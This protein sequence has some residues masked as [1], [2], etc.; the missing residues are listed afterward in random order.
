MTQDISF[1]KMH[2]IGNDFVIIDLRHTS[3]LLSPTLIRAIC[4]RQ[5]GIGCDQLVTLEPATMQDA[6]AWVKFYN[7]DGSESGACG[8]ASRCVAHYLMQKNQT[9]QTILQTSHDRLLRCAM[10]GDQVAVNMG[11]ASLE[12][13]SI[14]LS[15]PVDTLHI[16]EPGIEE[17][18]AVNIGNPHLVLKVNDIN[19]CDI[20]T[21]G[22]HLE[23]H[24]LFPQRANINF[25]QIIDRHHI[26][27]RVWE[28]GAGETLACGSGACATAV[29][30]YKRGWVGHHVRVD[31]PGGTLTID[32]Q[33]DNNIHMIGPIA[34]IFEGSFRVESFQ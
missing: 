11:A 25:A 18:V 6:H 5:T 33:D 12:W 21:K 10:D 20:A 16:N 27:L 24:P 32:V 1:I 15:K 22:P 8:N 28:R 7:N 26:K 4:H 31:L 13:Q 14:P 19:H 29:A 17:A 23:H 9:S 34:Y 30:A 3:I 2:G